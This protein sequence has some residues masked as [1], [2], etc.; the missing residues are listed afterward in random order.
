MCW[1]CGGAVFGN[2]AKYRLADFFTGVEY[3]SSTSVG[4]YINAYKMITINT[5]YIAI[6][7]VMAVIA[8]CLYLIRW[9]LIN[10]DDYD[11]G[12]PDQEDLQVRI[13]KPTGNLIIRI[14]HGKETKL[15]LPDD[16]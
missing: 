15:V 12:M 14:P 6:A 1:F 8:A 11:R 7:F 4:F 3:R 9:V 5:T 13:E 2:Y 16:I 10:I